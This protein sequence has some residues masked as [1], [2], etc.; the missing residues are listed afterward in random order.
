MNT[1]GGDELAEQEALR[2]N[3]RRLE[4]REE[5]LRTRSLAIAVAVFAEVFRS[6]RSTAGRIKPNMNPITLTDWTSASNSASGSA[7]LL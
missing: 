1:V 3:G 5:R 4:V 2:R 6:C 7:R